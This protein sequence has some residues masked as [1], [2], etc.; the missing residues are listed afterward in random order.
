MKKAEIASKLMDLYC[1]NRKKYRYMFRGRDGEAQYHAVDK[2]LTVMQ[3]YKHLDGL[4][5]VSVCAGDFDTVFSTFDIDEPGLDKVR[6]VLDKLAAL[7]IPQD[8]MYV[9]TS[10]NKGHHIDIFYDKPV[11]KSQGEN[12]FNHLRQDPEVAAIRLEYFPTGGKCIKLPLGVNFKTGR[13]C[14]FLDPQTLEP[15]ESLEYVLGVEKWSKAEFEAVVHRLNKEVFMDRLEQAQAYAAEKKAARSEKV[16]KEVREVAQAYIT[17]HAE[18]KDP[19]ITGPGQRHNLMLKVAVHRRCMGAPDAEAVYNEVMEWYGRQDQSEVTSS[20]REIEDDARAIARDV[21]NRYDPVM[22]WARKAYFRDQE[23]TGVITSLDLQNIL[24]CEKKSMRKVAMLV[25]AY[26]RCFGSCKMGYDKMAEKVGL[27]RS[28][29]EAAISELIKMKLIKWWKRGGT[30]VINGQPRPNPNEYKF[31]D[32]QLVEGAPSF[33]KKDTIFVFDDVRENFLA[34]YYRVL[35][36]MINPE[37]ISKYI[38]KK[39]MEAIG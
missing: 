37:E 17:K 36:R 28:T 7:G 6:L 10:G 32:Q 34:F 16:E 26:T 15:I 25:C 11:Y 30:I 9:S 33:M 35:M 13:R 2:P 3:I 5:T 21:C 23:K 12:L 31:T 1:F 19:V 27:A 38:S 20:E 14:W 4:M 29:V 8:K 22:T 24:L 18:D 39:E